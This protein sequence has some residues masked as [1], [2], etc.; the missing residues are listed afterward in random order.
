MLSVKCKKVVNV[1]LWA[2]TLPFIVLAVM[3]I[4]MIYKCLSW[5]DDQQ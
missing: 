2:V 1:Y 3:C 5:D 4:S